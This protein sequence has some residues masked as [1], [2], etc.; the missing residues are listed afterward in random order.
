MKAGLSRERWQ[1]LAT[2]PN[3]WYRCLTLALS[4]GLEL[5]LAV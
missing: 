5:I 2:A 3:N 4:G 1:R